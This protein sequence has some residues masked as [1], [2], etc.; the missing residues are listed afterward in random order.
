MPVRLVLLLPLYSVEC[1]G[2]LISE[3]EANIIIISVGVYK[4]RAAKFNSTKGY[5]S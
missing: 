1:G 3:D 2:V 4:Y 5:W